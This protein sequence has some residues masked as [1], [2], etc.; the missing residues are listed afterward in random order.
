M[1]RGKI[2]NR[3]RAKQ[4]RDFSGLCFGNIT[5]TDIDGL[6]EYHNR[7]YIIIELKWADTPVAFGQQLALE[8]LTDTLT[9]AG[10]PTLCIISSHTNNNP[11]QDIDVA[12]SLVTSFRLGGKWHE[13]TGKG[14]T[15]KKLVER[16]I[17]GKLKI[18]F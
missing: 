8:R 9:R 1:E 7:G 14:F 3:A 17:E 10:K 16:F 4:L 12:N 11:D 5:A 13:A 15:T 2:H 6:I 18:Y